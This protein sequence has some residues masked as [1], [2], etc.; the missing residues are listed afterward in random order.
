V[1][2]TEIADV[3]AV[4]R[5]SA[6]Q[7][8]AT[9]G[10]LEDHSS[11]AT[12][13]LGDVGV[14]V[15]RAID[16][17][18]DIAAATT[19]FMGAIRQSSRSTRLTADLSAQAAG[20][21]AH[22][23]DEM[24]RVQTDARAIGAI[25]DLIGTIA[26]RTRLLALNAAIEAARVGDAGRGFAVVADEVKS[27]ATQTARATDQIAEQIAGMQ[28]GTE[29]ACT[30]LLHIRAMV[31]EMAHGADDLA[32]SIGE[33]AQSGETISRNVDGA[34]RD[35]DLIGRLVT[36]VSTATR[37]AAGMASQV[38]SDARSVED[39]ASSIDRALSRFFG[40]LHVV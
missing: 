1:L 2:E 25:V 3:I 26:A 21:A 6:H 9:S 36:G 33:Q 32:S 24:T 23:A 40:E 28:S 39:S 22:L 8:S 17:A 7:L 30:G 12:R 38:R 18:T 19:Q 4:L 27:L 16:G 14:A 15:H 13:E 37:G 20:Q 11:G 35:L 5:G 31:E 10:E 34:A 29:A